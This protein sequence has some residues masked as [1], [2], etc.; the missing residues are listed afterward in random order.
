MQQ[1]QIG[2]RLRKSVGAGRLLQW[3]L[4]G[5]S[6]C[7]L[8]QFPALSAF[9][10]VGTIGLNRKHML[11]FNQLLLTFIVLISIGCKNS[12]DG[13]YLVFNTETTPSYGNPEPFHDYNA[14]SRMREMF[15]GKVF[16]LQFK[17]NYVIL[18]EDGSSEEMI[19]NKDAN[20]ELNDKIYLHNYTKD[21]Q[22]VELRLS[23]YLTE[24]KVRNLTLGIVITKLDTD[25]LGQPSDGKYGRIFCALEK[26]TK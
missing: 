20:S 13:D 8:V 21:G 12:P 23:D 1:E 2:S 4:L 14:S 18:K 7:R 3:A 11:K 15:K 16:N 17:P 9:N 25:S 19:L 26:R 24:E 6:E 10:R 5:A 22:K